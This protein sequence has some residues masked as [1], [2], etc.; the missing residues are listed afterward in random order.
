MTLTDREVSPHGRLPHPS[1]ALRAA[2]AVKRAGKGQ[3]ELNVHGQTRS[4][5]RNGQPNLV[6]GKEMFLT[7]NYEA[8]ENT[9]ARCNE[10]WSD[11]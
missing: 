11:V 5:N 3:K 8:Y 10:P 6:E 1:I 4:A 2:T 9:Y 7:A